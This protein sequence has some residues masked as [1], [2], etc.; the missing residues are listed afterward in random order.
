MAEATIVVPGVQEKVVAALLDFL[1]T[2]EMTVDRED[3]ADLQLLIDTLQIDPELIHVDTINDP[4]STKEEREDKKEDEEASEKAAKKRKHDEDSKDVEEEEEKKDAIVEGTEDDKR[5]GSVSD[6][7]K[8]GGGVAG[9]T[10]SKK[11]ES[12]A[13]TGDEESESNN[14]KRA[15]LKDD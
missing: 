9:E 5:P 15:K 4:A 1:Y 3:T 10:I 12:D 14:A 13:A 11:T 2:G 8:S 6:G 7:D